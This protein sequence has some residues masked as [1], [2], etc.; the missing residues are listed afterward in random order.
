MLISMTMCKCWQMKLIS[1][2]L[3][4]TH[5]EEIN[6]DKT[7]RKSLELLLYMKQKIKF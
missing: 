2:R 1:L 5:N 4:T 7:A 6:P 3:K